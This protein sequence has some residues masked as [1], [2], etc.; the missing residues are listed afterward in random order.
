M[1]SDSTIT[2]CTEAGVVLEGACSKPEC[3]R[4]SI[5]KVTGGP[6]LLV[7]E[8]SSAKVKGCTVS[9]CKVGIET[10]S[11]GEA[12]IVMNKVHDNREDGVLTRTEKGLRNDTIVRFN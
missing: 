2:G 5:D 11:A 6:G 4:L 10:V 7:K 1:V 9:H 3:L 8:G 12:L